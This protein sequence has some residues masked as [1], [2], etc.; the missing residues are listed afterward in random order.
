MDGWIILDK[1]KGMNSRKAGAILSR[2]F[3]AKTFGHIGT[4]DPMASGLLPIAL[5]QATKMIPYWKE[6]QKK[7]YLFGVQ[8]GFET[9]TLDITGRVVNEKNIVPLRAQILSA[10]AELMGEISQTPPTYS[11]V[12]VGGRRAYELARAGKSFDIPPRRVAIDTLELLE[13]VEKSWMFRIVCSPGTY[14]RAIARDLADMC[15]TVATVD[16]IRRIRTNGLDIK[17]A[18]RL[19]FLK[20]LFN[21][22]EGFE[23]YLKPMDFGLGDIPVL[24]LQDKDVNLYKQGGFIKMAGQ[25]QSGLARVYAGGQF[26]GIGDLLGDLLKPKRTLN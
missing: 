10:C 5:G 4:L 19:D 22:S 16:M 2:I 15:G 23:E 3:G 6:S 21:N 7:E 12:H 11:A 8:F 25:D 9:D 24:N 13:I 26:L 20:N 14:V 1:P 18:V 17:N